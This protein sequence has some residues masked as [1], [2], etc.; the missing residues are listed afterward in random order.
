[1]NY[2]DKAKQDAWD[3]ADNFIEEIIAQAQVDGVVSNDYNNDYNGGDNYHHLTHVDKSY[4]LLEAATLLDELKEHEETDWGLWEGVHDPRECISTQAAYTY[5]NAVG[6]YWN[7]IIEGIN[8]FL[9]SFEWE[10]GERA[11]TAHKFITVLIDLGCNF[12]PTDCDG[13]IA[14]ALEGIKNINWTPALVLCDWL[15]EHD[16]HPHLTKKFREMLQ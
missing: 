4:K 8:K 1:M 15:D 12:K 3:M 7:E 6:Y 10:E 9:D 14:A 11:P 13:M 16:S 2:T 5:G